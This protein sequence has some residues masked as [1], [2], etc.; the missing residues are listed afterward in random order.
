MR[1]LSF[2][3]LSL[4]FRGCAAALQMP[5]LSASHPASPDAEEA[6]LPAVSPTLAL[7]QGKATRG[8]ATTEESSEEEAPAMPSGGHTGHGGGHGH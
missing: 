7:P 6:P 5:P 3:F 4:T 2:V 8:A 1:R